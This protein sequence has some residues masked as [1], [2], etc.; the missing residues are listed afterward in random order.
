M[1]L[2]S[3]DK[4]LV[5]RGGVDYK[6][7]VGPLMG[8]GGGG[9]G[10]DDIINAPLVKGPV[11]LPHHVVGGEW[12]PMDLVD[13][14]GKSGSTFNAPGFQYLTGAIQYKKSLNPAMQT[15]EVCIAQFADLVSEIEDTDAAD[16]A[17]DA[18]IDPAGVSRQVFTYALGGG[19]FHVR[20]NIKTK[21]KI[22]VSFTDCNGDAAHLFITCQNYVYRSMRREDIDLSEMEALDAALTNNNN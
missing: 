15:S 17:P 10:L 20:G 8:G 19:T 13:G 3:T 22:K 9:G 18:D 2:K 7:N 5:N 1:A 14:D 11:Y 12:L 21:V 4:I 16:A 6:T